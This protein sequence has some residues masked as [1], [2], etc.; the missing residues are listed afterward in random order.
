VVELDDEVLRRGESVARGNPRS[1]A[2]WRLPTV[3][4]PRRS[5]G[6]RRGGLKTAPTECTGPR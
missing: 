2:A 1:K 3:R 4:A 6:F 5:R